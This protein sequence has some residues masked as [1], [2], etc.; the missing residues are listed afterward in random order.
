N[1]NTQHDLVTDSSLI[2]NEIGYKE[3]ISRK[4]SIR[5]TIEWERINPPENIDKSN[6]D[7]TMEDKI[8]SSL[9]V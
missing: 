4:E 5:R 6:F 3:Q 1:L 7:Y 9:K 8:M 2:R